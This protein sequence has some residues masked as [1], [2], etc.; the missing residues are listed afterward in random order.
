MRVSGFTILRHAG[1]LGYPFVESIRSVLPLVDEFIVLIADDD[2]DSGPAVEAIGDPRICIIRSPWNPTGIGGA[3]LGRLTNVALSR[4]T[5]AWA[6]YVQADE[7]IH[8]DDH[9]ALRR[10]MRDNLARDAEGLLFEYLHFYR[11]YHWIAN[12]W[13]AFY[14]RAVRAVRTGIGVESS[15]DAARFVRRIGTATRGLIKASSGARIFHYGWAGP[16]EARLQRSRQMRPLYSGQPST[17]TMEDLSPA[18]SDVPIRPH[19][20]T[21]PS[22]LRAIAAAQP[23]MLA[24]PAGVRSPAWLR[25]WRAALE[26]PRSF[27]GWARRLLPTSITNTRSRLI[28]IRRDHRARREDA[29]WVAFYRRLISP[30]DLVFDVGAHRG[31]RSRSF[32]SIGAQVVAF[33]PQQDCA[34]SL[35]AAFAG[36]SGFTL[37]QAAVSDTERV[38]DLHVSSELPLSTLDTEWMDRTHRSGRFPNSW[39]RRE[40]VTCTTLDKSIETFGVPAFIKIDVEGHELSVIRGLSYP[41][42]LLSMEFA[43]ESIDRISGCIHHLD[44]LASYEYRLSFAEST[45]FAG[46]EWA[47]GADIKAQLEHAR[48][49]DPLTWGDLYARRVPER[50]PD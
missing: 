32:R 26:D 25:A 27:R 30:S 49:N 41:V 45:Q 2:N 39:H 46:A 33:E 36:D 5:G 34:R 48:I 13:R 47:S 17:L 21:H 6:I 24:P 44:S 43:S 1:A 14:P 40:A 50:R 37:V 3:E 20:G 38:A 42:A 4:C 7:L 29:R 11:S 18:A 22:P 8:E 10:A 35:A 15:G 28:D 19:T 16:A 12:D 23:E 31:T 9:D